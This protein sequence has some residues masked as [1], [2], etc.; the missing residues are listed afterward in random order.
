MKCVSFFKKK[1]M[2]CDAHNDST[3]SNNVEVA[4]RPVPH[5]CPLVSISSAR[6]GVG[7][8]LACRVPEAGWC[9]GHTVW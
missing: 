5:S 9:A 7:A 4:P 8:S 3:L 6:V 2:H 1:Q